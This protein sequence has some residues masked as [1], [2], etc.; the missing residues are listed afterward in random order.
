MSRDPSPK[1]VRVLAGLS[2]VILVG[3]FGSF[4]YITNW[5]TVDLRGGEF[6]TVSPLLPHGWLTYSGD[7][8]KVGHPEEYLPMVL[9]NGNIE[10]V[11]SD[12]VIGRDYFTVSIEADSLEAIKIARE[13]EKYPAPIVVTIANYPGLQYTTGNNHIEFFIAENNRVVKITSDELNYPI[14]STMFATFA[15]N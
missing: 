15:F 9:I 8:W 2:M 4:G 1:F 11:P 10:F 7:G 5:F 6:D 12:R 14:V 3:V 13:K